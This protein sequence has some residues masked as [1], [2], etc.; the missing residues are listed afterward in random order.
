MTES[1][2][3]ASEQRFEEEASRGGATTRESREAGGGEESELGY[4]VFE[5]VAYEL[6]ATSLIHELECPSLLKCSKGH[7]TGHLHTH[8]PTFLFPRERKSTLPSF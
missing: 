7:S 6:L 3:S 2:V 1:G 8:F 4:E 5:E